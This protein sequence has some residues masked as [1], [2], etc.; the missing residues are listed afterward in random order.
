MAPFILP[1]GRL[2]VSAS[3]AATSAATA[4]HCGAHRA[5]RAPR[6]GAW[7]CISSRMTTVYI[8]IYIYY[9]YIYIYTHRYIY[10]D[11]S[12]CECV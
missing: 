4:H 10:M 11:L 3:E 6:D 1:A 12:V 5:R 9:M 2:G 7:T 8:Y